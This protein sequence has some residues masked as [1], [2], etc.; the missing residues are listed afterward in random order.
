MLTFELRCRLSSDTSLSFSGS[1]R[2][3]GSSTRTSLRC[4]LAATDQTPA[5]Y[6]FP[7]CPRNEPWWTTPLPRLLA[8]GIASA[9]QEDRSPRL[10][11]RETLQEAT[12][13]ACIADTPVLSALCFVVAGDLT[14]ESSGKS[15]PRTRL[16][17]TPWRLAFQM[18]SDVAGSPRNTSTTTSVPSTPKLYRQGTTAYCRSAD[19]PAALR[20]QFELE[21]CL[22]PQ[23]AIDGVPDAFHPVDVERFLVLHRMRTSPVRWDC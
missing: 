11:L 5:L 16:R 10:D 7:E 8:S 14:H 1:M 20:Q 15:L 6:G 23:P 3:L 19:L 12:F 18:L 17:L 4:D 2:N 13:T 22:R 9:L 21:H